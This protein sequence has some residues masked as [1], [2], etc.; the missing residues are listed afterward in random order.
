MIWLTWRQFRLQAAVLYGGVIVLAVILVATRPQLTHLYRT[1]RASFL[2]DLSGADR[3]LY[4][5]A[6]LSV[7]AVPVLIGMF[8][9]APLIARELDAGTSKLAWTLTT[10]TR[11]LAAKLGLIGLAAILAAGLLSLTVTWWAAPIDSAIAHIRG[12]PPPGLLVFPRLSRE[13]FDERG[14]VPLGYA[15]FAFVLGATLG[16]I[17]RRTLPAVALFLAVFAVV[18]VFISVAVRPHLFPPERMTTTITTGN[19]LSLNVANDLTVVINKPGAWVSSQELVNA[20]GQAVRTPAWTAH[21]L[22]QAGPRGASACL[23]RLARAG[24]RQVLIYQPASRFWAFQ[25]SE[26]GIYLGLA[27]VASLSCAWWV[28]YRL[29]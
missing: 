9:G 20:A 5:L 18:Q 26:T 15:A 27:A 17:V 24:Y 12:L 14:V 25:V 6:T 11:W 22:L 13:I 23:D 2:N 3:T 19:L 10:R 4:L 7:L 21:C 16:V 8:W 1:S 28:K 29:S